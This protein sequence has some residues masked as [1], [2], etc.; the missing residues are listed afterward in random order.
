MQLIL[1]LQFAQE[2]FHLQKTW[3]RGEVIGHRIPRHLRGYPIM[4]EM[5]YQVLRDD[6]EAYYAPEDD[7]QYIRAPLPPRRVGPRPD[8]SERTGAFND[9]P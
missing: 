1:P 7:D 8:W 4:K 5:A 3:Y 2:F 6:G 9:V